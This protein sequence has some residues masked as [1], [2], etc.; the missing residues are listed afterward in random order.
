MPR[1]LRR[2]YQL[3]VS[4]KG[5]R[6]PVSR[7]ILVSSS[8]DLAELH[9]ILQIAMGW[10]DSHLHQFAVGRMH[11]GQPDPDFDD[12]TI[13]ERGVRVDALLRDEGESF[14]YEYDFG[15]GWE[16]K[17]TLEK[18]LP[19]KSSHVTPRCIDGR[20]GCPPEDVGGIF[21]YSEFLQAYS[22]A[23]HP[24]HS[25]MRQWAGEYFD[26]ERFD[27]SEVNAVLAKRRGS[28]KRRAKRTRHG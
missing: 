14:V 10:T 26:P 17:V 9:S 20:R 27:V 25:D 6:P 16:H 11:Y 15:D 28:R 3:K 12:D 18:A 13:D 19:Y 21:G 23:G 2:T 8:V 4:L 5:V 22:D 24:Q 1:L 7:R